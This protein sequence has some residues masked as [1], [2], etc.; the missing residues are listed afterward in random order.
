M[1]N[2]K[3]A[4]ITAT[5]VAFVALG[6]GAIARRASAQAPH[7]E[8]TPTAGG[9][10]ERVA[11]K[12]GVSVEQLDQAVHDAALDA[13]NEAEAAGKITPEQATKARQRIED[14][15]G[16]GLFDRIRERSVD[17]PEHR[18][19]LVR[20]GIVRSAATALGMTPEDLRAE[21]QSGD[22]IADVA[23]EHGVSLEDVKA[24]ISSD[25]EAKLSEAVANGRLTEERADELLARLTAKL[26]E[27]LN[28]SKEPAAAR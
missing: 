21:L 5:I 9:F 1:M 17:R 12:L 28:K 18:L 22:S 25:A 8:A 6:A 14:G 26:D 27:I 20:R 11:E 4:L 3:K 15:K 2:T 23:S 7:G 16:A 10:K 19:T 13:V 24:R